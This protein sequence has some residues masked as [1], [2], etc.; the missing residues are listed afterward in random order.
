[1]NP[2]EFLQPHLGRS[3][4]LRAESNTSRQKNRIFTA[5][6]IVLCI[7]SLA[8]TAASAQ[9]KASTDWA[10]DI[11]GG[12]VGRILRVTTLAADGPG[13]L[14]EAIATQGARIVVF[15]VG[16]VIDLKRQSLRIVHPELTIAGQTA[17]SPGITLIR[18]GIEIHTHQVIIEHLRVRPGE[19]G[20]RKGSGWEVDAI[21]TKGGAH[22]VLIAHCS[23]TWATDENVSASGPRFDGKDVAAWRRATS[24]RVRFSDNIIAEGLAES[25]HAKGEH[26]KGALVHD[27]ARDIQFV[28]NLFAHNAERNPLFKGGAGGAIVNNLIYNPGARG[29]HY[30]L[31]A[32]EWETIAPV[33]GDLIV[34]GNAL[35]AGPSTDSDFAFFMLGGGGDLNLAAHDNIAV[36][37]IGRALP[38]Q[39]RYSTA[40]LQLN[41][42]AVRLPRGI[43]PMPAS[44]VQESVLRHAGARPW[45]RDAIDVRIIA[46][47]VEGRGRIISSEAEV[48]GYPVQA[49][50]ARVFDAALWDLR[51]MRPRAQVADTRCMGL[52]CT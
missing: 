44:A 10:A 51:S 17:P 38:M 7:A 5:A 50:T 2:F 9:P 49:P 18:G 19:A 28:G 29:I 20:M 36:D 42:V 12:R 32:W 14:R 22:D 30:N 37:R 52:E 4:Q 39:G 21:A 41:E 1:M 23:L 25:T 16:G 46:D 40:P 33:N 31:S 47:T 8:P 34:V 15:E 24:H 6:M 11:E 43:A 3:P 45:A 13:S 48:G 35:R 26:S 27:N